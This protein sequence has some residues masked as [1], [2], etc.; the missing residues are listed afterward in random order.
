MT[1]IRCTVPSFSAAVVQLC[2]G[3][4]SSPSLQGGR[5]L[6]LFLDDPG[7]HPSVR[8]C[9]SLLAEVHA[10]LPVFSFDSDALLDPDL[11]SPGSSLPPGP[12]A[13]CEA[14]LRTKMVGLMAQIRGGAHVD[15]REEG[16]F[17]EAIREHQQVRRCYE[18]DTT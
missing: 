1:S 14:D 11:S 4:G 8:H 5:L 9:W 7:R 13:L 3:L 15:Q 18:A 17:R 6:G 12:G 10:D 2:A 16:L